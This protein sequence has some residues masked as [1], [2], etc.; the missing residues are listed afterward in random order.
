MTSVFKAKRRGAISSNNP[1][2]LTQSLESKNNSNMVDLIDEETTERI[3]TGISK[4]TDVDSIDL[5]RLSLEDKKAF[6]DAYLWE[7]KSK[8]VKERNKTFNAVLKENN[9]DLT[10][11]ITSLQQQLKRNNLQV[12]VQGTGKVWKLETKKGNLNKVDEKYLTE[13]LTDFFIVKKYRIETA[14]QVKL[15]VKNL[16][17]ENL[18]GRA[19]DGAP[20]AVLVADKDIILEDLVDLPI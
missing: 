10:K 11:R 9:E 1:N 2:Q 4:A 12:R 18:R 19:K 3:N 13:A 16:F 6:Q 15:L 5:G 14:E 20:K 17:S 7:Q 8:E